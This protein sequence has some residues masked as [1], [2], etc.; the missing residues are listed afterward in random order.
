MN[1]KITQHIVLKYLNVSHIY[2]RIL[3]DMEQQITETGTKEELSPN[4]A[5]KP[6]KMREIG[7]A[8]V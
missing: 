8:H 1:V 2:R 7:R 5:L 6:G 3:I 4:F